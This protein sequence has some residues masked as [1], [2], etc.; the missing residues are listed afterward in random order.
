[1]QKVTKI[2]RVYSSVLFVEKV[3]KLLGREKLVSF[4]VD[5][6]IFIIL[7]QFLSPNPLSSLKSSFKNPH[8]KISKIH[9]RKKTNKEL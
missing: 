2:S 8:L 7:K 5:I 9:I 4:A 6:L 3:P 1:M